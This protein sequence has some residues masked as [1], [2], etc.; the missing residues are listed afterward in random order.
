MEGDCFGLDFAVF[1]VDFVAAEDDGDVLAY[2]DQVA[3]MLEETGLAR[4]GSERRDVRCQLGT[5]L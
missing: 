3:Y 2:T 4:Q 1:D 5:F